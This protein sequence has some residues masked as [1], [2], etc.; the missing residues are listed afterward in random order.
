MKPKSSKLIAL[1]TALPAAVALSL[2]TGCSVVR[3]NVISSINTGFGVQ[4]VEN[5]QTQVPELKIGYIRSQ[6]YSIPTAKTVGNVHNTLSGQASGPLNDPSKTP[7]LVSGIR[8]GAKGATG[9]VGMDISENF[10]VGEAAVNSQAAIAMYIAQ[11]NV[12]ASAQAASSAVTSAKVQLEKDQKTSTQVV[13]DITENT[14][15]FLEA[16]LD[17]TAQLAQDTNLLASASWDKISPAAV[18]LQ[19][20]RETKKRALLRQRLNG[21]ALD[22]QY[23]PQLTQLRDLLKR[24]FPGYDW[25]N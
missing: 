21:A 7:Q 3:E 22:P 12:P 23:Q 13:T 11:A 2:G 10:A 16:D 25:G 15:T 20:T 4:V 19:A 9:G 24:K 14:D 6:F 5:P 17:T 1:R 18:P 8:A